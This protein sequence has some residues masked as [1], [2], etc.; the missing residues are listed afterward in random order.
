MQAKFDYD[1]V[2][3][4]ELTTFGVN[5]PNIQ[6]TGFSV[7]PRISYSPTLAD[8]IAVDGSMSRSIYD[9]RAFTDYDLFSVK[10]SYAHNFDPN[11]TGTFAVEAQR[12]MATVANG[13][14]VDSIGPTVGWL[15]ALTP[16]LTLAVNGGIQKSMQDA[17]ATASSASAWN[18]IFGGDLSYK[19][20]KDT[21]DL[22]ASRSQYPFGNG[23]ETLLTS[24]GLT[25]S[26]ALNPY[27][28]LNGSLLYQ[29]AK[30]PPGVTSF[31]LNTQSI[32][33]AGLAYHVL[34]HIDITASYQYRDESLTNG[35]GSVK[36]QSAMIGLTYHPL[37]SAAP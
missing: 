16:K 4:S 6:H 36:D 30:E 25:E 26:H 34:P 17:T 2:R 35:G 3:T 14:T 11:N 7:A 27:I 10:P 21:T 12:Y 37:A 18:Y 33:N 29:F 5:I 24:F 28:S 31:N 9:N 13:S 15:S 32:G 19:G 23:T 20:L 1:T 8:K 22:L